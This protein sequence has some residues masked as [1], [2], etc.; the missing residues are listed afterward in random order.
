M[1]IFAEGEITRT[2]GL[3]PFRR[4]LTR[5]LKGHDVP[6]IPTHLDRVWGSVMSPKGGGFLRSWNGPIP[7][8]ITLSFGEPLPAETPVAEIREAVILLDPVD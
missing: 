5:I 3:L 2:G 7:R 1:C 6:V 4:G 8:P